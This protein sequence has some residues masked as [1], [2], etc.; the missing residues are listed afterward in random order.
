MTSVIEM[1]MLAGPPVND[2]APV[3]M[4]ACLGMIAILGLVAWAVVWAVPRRK[5]K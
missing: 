1:M 4:L 2:E 5:G 3:G